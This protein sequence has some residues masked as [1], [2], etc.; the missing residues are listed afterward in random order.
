MPYRPGDTLTTQFTTQ[1]GDTGAASDADELPTAAVSR[2]GVDDSGVTPTVTNLA[3]G[4]YRVQ[5]TIP[6]TYQPGDVVQIVVSATVAGVTGVAV[7][8]SFVIDAKRL[9]DLHDF[10][11][12]SQSVVVSDL[13]TAAMG[14]LFTID[15]GVA[16]AD[17][18]LGSVVREIADHTGL[19]WTEEERMQIR[20]RLGLDGT[21]SA[22]LT[23][24]D[25]SDIKVILQAATRK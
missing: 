18:V 10:D 23:A 3:T 11:P 5:A 12:A 8:D 2:N 16:F 6:E 20:H 25:L 7:V 17:A 15:T 24:G 14:S 1:R 13:T 9:A 4:R 19:G 22:P 21:K